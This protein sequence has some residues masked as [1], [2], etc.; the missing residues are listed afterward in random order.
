MNSRERVLSSLRHQE[1]D[2]VPFDLGGTVVTGIHSIAYQRLRE[3]LG[4][5]FKEPHIVDVFQQIVQVDEDVMDR[6]GIDVKNVAP[7]SSG[8][9]KIEVQDMGEYTSFS[10]EFKI[11]WRMP[12]VG[13]LYY[14][15]YKHPLAGDITVE[16]IRRYPMPD[17]LDPSRFVGL[18]QKAQKVAEEEKRA[19][20][21]GSMSAGVLEITAWTRGFSDYFADLGSNEILTCTMMDRVLEQK[22][23]FWGRAL[24]LIGDY[25]DV[26]QEAD[27]LAG[28][29]NLLISPQTYRRLVKPRH[30][31]LFDF[32]HTHS[33]AKVFFHSCG[34]IRPIIPDL[35]E[36]GIDILNPV[37]VSAAGMDTAKLK[38]D[39]GKDLTFWGGGVDTQAVLSRGTPAEIRSEVHHRL[40]DLMADG[41]FVFN[42][43]HNIQADV[44]PENIMAMWNALQEFGK[45]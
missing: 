21:M 38:N 29:F 30:K 42:A 34:A 27:D 17:P 12:K 33:N 24:E 7:R 16:D 45:Y 28:Q 13:G 35:I 8:T 31:I 3:Y 4:L 14:D 43:V 6:L 5:P 39:F 25:I 9:Y 41:G 44:A 37:Q 40:D 20:V 2:R 15:M 22:L 19:V 26:A 23:A 32:I 18:R 10:D 36:V 1:P 11:G